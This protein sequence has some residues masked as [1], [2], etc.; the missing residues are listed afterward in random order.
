MARL[1]GEGMTMEKN[2][3]PNR[4]G[5]ADVPWDLRS[6]P[7]DRLGSTAEAMQ[8]VDD[9]LARATGPWLKVVVAGFNSAL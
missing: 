5:R 4:V 1:Y 7:L 6:V 9:I 8:L 3:V 2:G